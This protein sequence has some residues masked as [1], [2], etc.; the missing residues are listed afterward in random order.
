MARPKSDAKRSAILAAAIKTIAEHGLSAPT[1]MIANE[2]GVSNGA[3][4]TYFE[5]K[6]DLFNE[7]Y[8]QLKTDMAKSMTIVTPADADLRVQLRH[9]WEQCLYWAISH[10]QER[11]AIAC[12]SVSPDVTPTTREAASQSIHEVVALLDRIRASG[13]MHD[14]PLMFVG[15][16]VM[17]LIEATTQYMAEDPANAPIHARTGF[18]ALWRMVS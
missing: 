16:L 8:L 5:T 12:L 6:A 7:A 10:P 11:K 18:E 13:A 1:A 3:L 15:S 2:A 17:A 9:V 14:A 4:F